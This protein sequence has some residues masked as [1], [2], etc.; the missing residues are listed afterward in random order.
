LEPTKITF[1]AVASACAKAQDA[2][3]A[4]KL[5]TTMVER[6]HDIDPATY[7]ALDEASVGDSEHAIALRS[8][9][10]ALRT[11]ETPTKVMSAS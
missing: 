2:A 11:P 5:L 1:N 8:Q 7:W 6:Q 10:K 3:R 9:L 4:I